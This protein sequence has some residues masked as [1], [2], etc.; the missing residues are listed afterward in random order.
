MHIYIYCLNTHTLFLACA[1]T[2]ECELH[3][4]SDFC[5]F[6][7]IISAKCPEMYSIHKKYPVKICWKNE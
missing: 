2:Q 1:P 5:I 3:E 7:S 6:H 4:S